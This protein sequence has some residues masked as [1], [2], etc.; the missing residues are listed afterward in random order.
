MTAAVLNVPVLTAGMAQR[1]RWPLWALALPALFV[2]ALMEIWAEPL[3]LVT[4]LGDSDDATRLV[5]VRELLAGAPWFDTT[6]SRLGA[7]EPLVSHWSRLVDAPLALLIS[8]FGLFV[9][10]EAAELAVR[11]I[12]PLLVLLPVL[13]VLARHAALS[14][15]RA[16]G[17]LALGFAVYAHTGLV[18]FAIGRIDH[19]NVMIAATV[20]GILL[21]SEGLRDPR[22][23]HLAGALLG[24]STAVGY[25]A[26]VLN[27]L[28]LIV[29]GLAGCWTGRL[30]AVQR[31]AWAFAAMLCAA[32]VVTIAP[33]AWFAVKCDALSAN[34]AV[35]ALAGAAGLTL[36]G[37]YQLSWQGRLIAAAA[38]M[39]PALGLFAVMEPACLAGPFGQVD[40]EA[41]RIWLSNVQEV[42]S[43]WQYAA[44]NPLPA[45]QFAIAAVMA[46][47]IAVLNLRRRVTVAGIYLLVILAMATLL[48][49]WQ[50]KLMPY[51]T[52]LGVPALAIFVAR[53]RPPKGMSL[54]SVRLMGFLALNQHTIL[55]PLMLAAQMASTNAALV[56]PDPEAG[57]AGG[58]DL[59]APA[60]CLES[61]EVRPLAALPPGLLV[62]D[63]DFGPF[64][65]ALTGLRVLSA[66]YHRLDRSILETET[67]KSSNAADAKLRLDAIGADYIA[68]CTPFKPRNATP[69][70]LAER[71]HAS[72]PP[73]YLEPITLAQPSLYKVWRI[74]RP[75][76]KDNHGARASTGSDGP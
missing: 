23:A 53:L 26:L 52:F 43:I 29:A 42:Q 16:A 67:I 63:A 34:L 4:G 17:I 74:S 28:A 22:R 46:L 51:A 44:A 37:R 56:T 60:R 2:F 64:I 70:T 31:T 9:S 18:Q 62:T 38:P 68:I 50:I 14:A 30:D 35:L 20:A 8:L 6:L 41:A 13:I 12:W 33:S 1:R 72:Q 73:S 45:G 11:A 7:P 76:P 24:L 15:G 47:A 10:R 48:A 27:L 58:G 75:F 19:H 69:G 61:A 49:F 39:M 36:A 3:R 71:L 65:V 54:L 40:A 25:E 57:V 66:P 32:M 55:L 5:T 59:I 21:L